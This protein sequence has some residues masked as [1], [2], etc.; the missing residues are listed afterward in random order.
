MFDQCYLFH[1][2]ALFRPQVHI[3][4][5]AL[6]PSLVPDGEIKD[7]NADKLSTQ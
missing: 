2:N 6:L 5:I 7:P 4:Y 1:G 3:L